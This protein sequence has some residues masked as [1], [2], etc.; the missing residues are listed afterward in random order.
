MNEISLRK[1]FLTLNT[2][3]AIALGLAFL[4]FIFFRL[5]VDVSATWDKV[6]STDPFLYFLAFAVYYATFPLRGWRWYILL[7]NAGVTPSPP[8]KKLT[9]MV[10]LSFFANCILY[11]RLGEVYRAYLIK[12]EG[13]SF[14]EALGTIVTERAV[15]VVI[16][17]SLLVLSGIILWENGVWRPVFGL[18]AVIAAGLLL[19]LALL[20]GLGNFMER[21][22][23]S[24]L[25]ELFS[26]FRR[27]ALSSLRRLP[28]VGLQGGFIWLL[29]S[30]RVFL[31]AWALGIPFDPWLAV[32][33]AQAAGIIVALPLTPGGLGLVES[34]IAGVL[35]LALPREE[36]WSIALVD[37]TVSY[38]S[39]IFF[40]LL[41][42]IYREFRRARRGL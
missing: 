4:T 5:D 7:S 12:E 19:A 11:A 33:V 41:L 23:P 42:L 26:L 38:L 34:G 21:V 8:V 31:I 30:F 9:Q 39:L 27:G 40:G 20:K 25:K 13:V 37:R 14:S 6:K 16:V 1:R 2:F 36:A 22:L 3:I 24:R 35:M 32:F 15:D 17:L 28:L 18:G 10:L 29:E